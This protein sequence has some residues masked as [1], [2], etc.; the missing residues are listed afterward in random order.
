MN[1]GEQTHALRVYRAVKMSGIDSA[2]LLT[3]ALLHDVGKTRVPLSPWQRA[4][5]VAAKVLTPQK[6]SDWGQGEP[7]GWRKPFVVAAHHA[8]WGA[9]MAIE[10]G[11][12]EL[13]ARLI[14]EHQTASPNGL[15]SE[16]AELLSILQQADDRN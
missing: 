2:P 14:R 10:G 13:T 9:Q 11:A 12:E 4:I 16:E 5:V 3:A 15:T 6:I 7:I 1:G 8:E